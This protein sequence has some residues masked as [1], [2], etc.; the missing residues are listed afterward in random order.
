MKAVEGPSEK[1]KIL[2]ILLME[3]I[4]TDA[5]IF[6]ITSIFNK[7]CQMLIY[8]VGVSNM[9]IFIIFLINY[10]SEHILDIERSLSLLSVTCIHWNIMS[11]FRHHRA[12][13]NSSILHRA[14]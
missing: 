7:K 6:N 9:T 1:M 14:A 2:M 8:M 12:T 3:N 13:H 11:F 4:L 10:F 5:L